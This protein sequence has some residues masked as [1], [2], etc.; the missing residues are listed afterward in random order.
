MVARTHQ[1][2]FERRVKSSA[3]QPTKAEL[4][5]ETNMPSAVMKSV[6]RTFFKPIKTK[7]RE[8]A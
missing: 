7:D 6:R 8:V 2:P 1:S 3:C 4:E 5:E